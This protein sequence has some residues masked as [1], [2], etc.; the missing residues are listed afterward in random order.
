MKKKQWITGVATILAVLGLAWVAFAQ[1]GSAT[2]D[3]LKVRQ[4]ME[5]MEGIL[6]TT[7]RF[8]TQPANASEFALH[9]IG[10]NIQGYFLLGQGAV[11]IIPVGPVES[12][13]NLDAVLALENSVRA[14]EQQRVVSER[15]L[16][17]IEREVRE[18]MRSAALAER[19]AIRAF[20]FD[21]DGL[22]EVP[23]P[24][25]PTE[26]PEPPPAP[27]APAV[28]PSPTPPLAPGAAERSRGRGSDSVAIE[29]SRERQA[30]DAQRRLKELEE[31]LAER[32]VDSEKRLKEVEAGLARLREGLVD[33]MAKHGDSLTILRPQ[34]SISL[35]L[36]GESGRNFPL[37]RVF[38]LRDGSKSEEA[39]TTVLSVKKADVTDLKAG[40]ISRE[41]F[42]QKVVQYQQ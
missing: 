7:I 38:W 36:T 13:A 33:A 16:R 2:V 34:D 23:E 19:D 14:A 21:W 35:I 41:Q 28:A 4:E 3:A 37:G 32:K 26:T 15:Y 25:E 9:D 10:E 20:S 17:D 30:V 31:R 24:P 18:A 42:L 6:Q 27:D 40:R 5:T 1:T 11:F 22:P 39:A 12:R 8:A 29:R